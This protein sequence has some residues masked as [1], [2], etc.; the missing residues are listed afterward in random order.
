MSGTGAAAGLQSSVHALQ[1]QALTSASVLASAASAP[2]P[3]SMSRYVVDL[4]GDGSDTDSSA[5]ESEDESDVD[6]LSADNDDDNKAVSFSSAPAAAPA[7]PAAAPAAA[8]PAAGAAG[9]AGALLHEGK[10]ETRAALKEDCVMVETKTSRL[11]RKW[12]MAYDLVR[13][14][15]QHGFRFSHQSESRRFAYVAARYFAQMRAGSGEDAIRLLKGSP[16]P[17]EEQQEVCAYYL[18]NM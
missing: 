11:P 8:A 10:V 15:W 5:T 12:Q 18:Y 7:A 14:G 1:G 4:T 9:A 17:Q 2:A 13:V 3:Q 6:M 16:L